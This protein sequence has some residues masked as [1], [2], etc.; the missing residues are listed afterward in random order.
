MVYN[1]NI[2][3]SINKHIRANWDTKYK[4][5]YHDKTMEWREN[6]PDEYRE[7]M[8]VYMNKRYAYTKQCKILMNISPDYFF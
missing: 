8:R 7:L 3:K 4:Q 6:H 5:Y 1:D 2:R